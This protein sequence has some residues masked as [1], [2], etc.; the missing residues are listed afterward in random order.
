M[1]RNHLP[2][3]VGEEALYYSPNNYANAAGVGSEGGVAPAGIFDTIAGIAKHV[4]GALTGCD[5]NDIG[6]M[7]ASGAK[8]AAG[9]LL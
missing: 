9:L 6:C 1:S 3:F 2:G 7:V 5:P 4:G 8:T